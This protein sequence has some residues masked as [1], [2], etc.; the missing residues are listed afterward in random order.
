MYGRRVFGNY[1]NNLRVGDD[2]K[3]TGNSFTRVVVVGHCDDG[4][5]FVNNFAF[6]VVGFADVRIIIRNLEESRFGSQ[7]FELCTRS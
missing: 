3:I 5:R 1:D 4:A 2:W 7:A 6:L